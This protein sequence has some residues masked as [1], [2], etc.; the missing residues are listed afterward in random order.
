MSYKSTPEQY[1]RVAVALHWMGALL[2]LTALVVGFRAADLAD[3]EAKAAL[4]R[5]HVAAGISAAVLTAGRAAWWLIDR[6]PL[7]MA[8]IGRLEARLAYGAHLVIYAAIFVMAAS[9]VATVLLSGAWPVLFATTGGELPDFADYPTRT[10]H[11]AGA[12]VLSALLLLHVGAAL[13]HHFVR[14]DRLLRRMWFARSCE[15]APDRSIAGTT[16][17]HS[18]SRLRHR[19]RNR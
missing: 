14:R 15:P 18:G 11:G 5:V 8:G 10:V 12:Q 1:G 9:G 2:V 16:S 17:P 6:R 19:G 13:Y 7:P 4:L 3:A